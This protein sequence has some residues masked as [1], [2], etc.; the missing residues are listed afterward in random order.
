MYHVTTVLAPMFSMDP[1]GQ[2][3]ELR[4]WLNYGIRKVS[5]GISQFNINCAG[6]NLRTGLNGWRIATNEHLPFQQEV[7]TFQLNVA[8]PIQVIDRV[9]V[10]LAGRADGF[11]I[12]T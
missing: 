6:T 12:A 10:V 2:L 3:M 4:I 8:G 9:K 7:Y 11:S 5:I 1:D